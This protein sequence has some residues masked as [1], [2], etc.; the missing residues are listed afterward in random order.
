MLE[1]GG[2]NMNDM[3]VTEYL[4]RLNISQYAP[5][6]AKKKVYFLSDL[7]D[8]M[9]EGAMESQFKIEDIMLRKRIMSM[10]KD[11]KI[12][13]QDF[14]LLTTNQVRQI[15]KQFVANP[16]LQEQLVEACGYE[17]LSGF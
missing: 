9:D 6:F 1:D 2:N 17:V 14:A 3:T 12:V 10:M 5:N 15:V 13:Q 4:R 7:K 11:D 8:Y 16:E